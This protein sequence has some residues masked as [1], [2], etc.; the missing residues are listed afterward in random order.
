MS[1]YF[2]EEIVAWVVDVANPTASWMTGQV[3][4]I[5]GGLSMA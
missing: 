2:T 4:A 1:R 5:E 3:I